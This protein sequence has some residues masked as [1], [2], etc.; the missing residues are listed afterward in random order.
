MTSDQKTISSLRNELDMIVKSIA[1]ET[2]PRDEAKLK[3]KQ[4]KQKVNELLPDEE[5]TQ[6]LTRVLL[7][8]A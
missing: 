1:N 8:V 6:A 2:L 4:L 3:L 5:T 7:T